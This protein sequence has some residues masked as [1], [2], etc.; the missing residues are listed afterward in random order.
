MHLRVIVFVGC[1]L[2]MS[3]VPGA[4]QAAADVSPSAPPVPGRR[5]LAGLLLVTGLWTVA[6]RGARRES[7]PRIVVRGID[8][9][10]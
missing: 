4:A 1:V 9:V 8:H 7:A 3:V 10:E 5:A 2:L 6:L